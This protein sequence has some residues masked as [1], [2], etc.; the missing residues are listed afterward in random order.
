MCLTAIVACRSDP[1]ARDNG[2][3]ITL[4]GTKVR[5]MV[6]AEGNTIVVATASQG[7]AETAFMRVD[8]ATSERVALTPPLPSVCGSGAQGIHSGPFAWSD[9]VALQ[10]ECVPV[11]Q[12]GKQNARYLVIHDKDLN[13]PVVLSRTTLQPG[14]DG[15]VSADSNLRDYN[16][17]TRTARWRSKAAPSARPW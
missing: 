6:W 11:G 7:A 17:L 12:A 1:T 16:R 14:I 3:V 4:S 10:I 8:A 13:T 5:G 2:R 15:K 9:H